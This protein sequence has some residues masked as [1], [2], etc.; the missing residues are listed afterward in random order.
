MVSLTDGFTGQNRVSSG[1][2]AAA[3]TG[4]ARDVNTERALTEYYDAITENTNVDPLFVLAIFEHESNMGLHGI[5][6]NTHSWGNMR[7]PPVGPVPFHTYHDPVKGDYLSF[8]SWLDGCLATA[9]HLDSPLYRGLTI[10]Q[11]IRKWAPAGDGAN[12]PDAYARG[13]VDFMNQWADQGGQAM[14]DVPT[15]DEIG[16][17]VTIN[18]TGTRGPERS[19][20]D[21]AWF[22]V[23]DG[24]GGY[25]SV[26]NT[27]SNNPDASAHA[28]IAHSG[29]LTYMVPIEFTAWHPGNNAVAVASIGVEQEGFADAHD[30]GYTDDQYKSMAAFFRWCARRGAHIPPRYIGKDDADGGPLP[31]NDGILGHQDVPDGRG[32][33]GGASHHTDPGPSYDFAILEAAINAGQ[34][35]PVPPQTSWEQ[36]GNPHPHVPLKEPF[37]NRYNAL[38]Q[39]R[40]GLGLAMM[41]WALAPEML[42]Q[43]LRVQRFQRGWY[44]VNETADDPWNV[45][46]LFPEE[47]P[48]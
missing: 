40:A 34:P 3:L 6:T 31:D 37:W 45:V 27:L 36:P 7:N 12:D 17:P 32:G 10:Q 30:G 46:A 1:K 41:G 33:W 2:F 14:S 25:Q 15:E 35:A 5:A 13:V 9:Y 19:L 16:Y 4:A 21:V 22:V 24:E 42:W 44:G 8:G 39:Q 23:H 43:G 48:R 20:N 18:L 38:E 29:A 11:A 47:W 28:V 26:V